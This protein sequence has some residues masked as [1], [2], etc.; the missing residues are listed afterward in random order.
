MLYDRRRYP[1]HVDCKNHCGSEERAMNCWLIYFVHDKQA[2]LGECLS[3]VSH[4]QEWKLTEFPMT[5]VTRSKH[6]QTWLSSTSLLTATYTVLQFSRI[7]SEL[8]TIRNYN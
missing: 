7:E 2:A 5:Y 8:G 4:F 3:S 1:N 6:K